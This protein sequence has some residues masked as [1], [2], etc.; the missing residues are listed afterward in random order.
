MNIFTFAI[1]YVQYMGKVAIVGNKLTLKNVVKKFTQVVCK[2]A[3]HLQ[4]L[5]NL[6]FLT[7]PSTQRYDYLGMTPFQ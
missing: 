2:K 1:H 7:A 5:K 6:Y 3:R 4:Y